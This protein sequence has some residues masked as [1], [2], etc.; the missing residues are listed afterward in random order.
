MHLR[1]LLV[2]L[3]FFALLAHATAQWQTQ[4]IG[5]GGETTVATDG[6]GHVYV[7]GHLPCTLFTSTDW[8]GNFKPTQTFPDAL[9]DMF[10][11]ARPD[12]H[13]NLVYGR[14]RIDGIGTWYSTD[15]AQTLNRGTD[16]MGPYDREWTTVNATTGR[17]F[18]DYSDGYIGGPKSKGVFL[19]KSD[20]NGNTFSK[21]VRVDR[22]PANSYAV[23][24]YITRLPAGRILCMW[25]VSTDYNTIDAFR[26]AY[27]DDEGKT[28]SIPQ[29]LATFDKAVAGKPV[30]TQE[31]WILGSITASGPDKVVITYPGY[32]IVTVDRRPTKVFLQHYRVST[33]SGQ[34]FG[35]GRAVLS[36]LELSAAVRRF[37]QKGGANLAYPYYIENLPWLA[38]DP[39]GHIHLVFIDNRD[40][41]ASTSVHPLANWS[42]RYAESDALPGDFGA[43]E[44]LSEDYAAR[45][46]PM[47]FISCAADSKFVYASWTETPNSNADYPSAQIFT[48]D[49]FVGRKPQK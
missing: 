37:N 14:T 34:T 2:P 15:F 9:G 32:E 29:T 27:S 22:E 44:P 7:T 45:R 48:G 17:I 23:D 36:K 25:Q 41:A 6:I 38:A 19:V 21:P 11:M 31:R 39:A 24:P 30:D 4:K 13:V 12:G 35:P 46:P 1:P 20:D 40:G 8:G 33:D 3:S 18:M 16:P 42:V 47:D 10:V 26:L 43:S 5:Q 49:L 28:F